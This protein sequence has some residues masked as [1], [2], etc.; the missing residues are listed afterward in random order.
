L[1]TETWFS[2]RLLFVSEIE[3]APNDDRLC[4]ESVI[5]VQA[6]DEQTAQDA[7]QRIAVTMEHGY[8]N[9]RGES[10][11]WRLLR[12]LEI[13][14]LCATNLTSGTEVWSRMFYESQTRDSEVLE[15][16]APTTTA[17]N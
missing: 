15:S 3:R 12:V 2:V 14:D 13:Q 6:T 9:D 17:P 1:A 5:I 11:Q 16:L 8:Q 10:V 7:A 4:E